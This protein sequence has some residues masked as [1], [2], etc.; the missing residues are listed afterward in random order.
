MAP[1]PLMPQDQE[2]INL[3]KFFAENP[4]MR[5][6]AVSDGFDEVYSDPV[7]ALRFCIDLL[8]HYIIFAQKLSK[9]P[10]VREEIDTEKVQEALELIAN[11]CGYVLT[12]QDATEE[13]L[14]SVMPGTKFNLVVPEHKPM[15]MW[16]FVD[17]NL[18]YTITFA[19]SQP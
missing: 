16:Y 10:S 7:M 4:D 5:R 17:A 2:A 18:K 14:Q 19:L 9:F 11:F 1:T 12:I 8:Y 6:G 3:A 13:Q 15:E